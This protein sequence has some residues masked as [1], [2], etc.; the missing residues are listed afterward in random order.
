MFFAEQIGKYTD[1]PS[2]PNPLTTQTE[3]ARYTQP[4]IQSCRKL[5]VIPCH[6]M[7][8]FPYVMTSFA[9]LQYTLY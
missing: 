3:T 2:P 1:G 7:Q 8:R 4:H 9:A 6:H 5:S